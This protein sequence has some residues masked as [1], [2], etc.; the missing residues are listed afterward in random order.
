MWARDSKVRG[1]H[2]NQ[3]IKASNRTDVCHVIS[4]A[5]ALPA[6]CR[7][8]VSLAADLLPFLPA[9]AKELS[10]EKRKLSGYIDGIKTIPPLQA[11]MYYLRALDFKFGDD[12][13]QAAVEMAKSF[14]KRGP[15]T[16]GDDPEFTDI[17]NALKKWRPCPSKSLND[18]MADMVERVLVI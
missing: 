2:E 14:E 11:M 13:E 6:H 3:G 12:I 4:A 16:L 1:F 7:A 9:E 18:T 10:I 15:L 17:V 5:C 8:I